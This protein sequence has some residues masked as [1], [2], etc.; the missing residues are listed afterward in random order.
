MA[1]LLLVASGRADGAF[2]S[3]LAETH[4]QGRVR[5]TVDLAP[6]EWR[7]IAH[8]KTDLLCASAGWTRS[9]LGSQR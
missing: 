3:E 4:S 5:L 6:E 2:E 9:G 1:I 7:T 8:P